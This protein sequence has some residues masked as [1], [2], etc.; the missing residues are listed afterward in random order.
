VHAEQAEFGHLRHDLEREDS[1][2]VPS[3]D[4]GLDRRVDEGAHLGAQRDLL[5]AEEGVDADQV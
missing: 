1:V 3:G 4:V 5:G 2:L